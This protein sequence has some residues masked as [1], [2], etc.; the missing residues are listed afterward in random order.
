MPDL[1]FSIVIPLTEPRGQATANIRSWAME[2]TLNRDQYEL[3]LVSNAPLGGSGP[4]LKALLS[5]Q[6]SIVE[7]H[8]DNEFLLYDLGARKAKGSILVFTEHHCIAATNCLEALTAYFATNPNGAAI[9]RNVGANNNF[10]AAMEDRL[11]REYF[12][13]L[14][15]ND[16]WKAVAV[17]GFAIKRKVYFDRGGLRYEFGR[18]GERVLAIEL[19]RSG[20]QLGFATDA[21]ITHYNTTSLHEIFIP[22]ERVAYGELSYRTQVSSAIS[23]DYLEPNRVWANREALRSQTARLMVQ[24]LLHKGWKVGFT[25]ADLRL[26]IKYGAASLIGF[27]GAE[28]SLGITFRRTYAAAMLNVAVTPASYTVEIHLLPGEY[29]HILKQTHIYFDGHPVQNVSI[30]NALLRFPVTADLFTLRSHFLSLI[31]SFQAN[32]QNRVGLPVTK[33]EFC[34]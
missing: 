31:S 14:L 15:K 17:R 30:E 20:Q 7:E 12:A 22:Q 13:K 3:I 2:Q 5:P 8:S 33:I 6:D 9:L 28:S 23:A 18:F 32:D 34:P 10:I 24:T 4:R 16:F 19:D 29:K 26:L 11:H 1:M 27:Q 21:I 25:G